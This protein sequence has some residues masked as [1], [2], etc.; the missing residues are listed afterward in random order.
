MTPREF[1]DWLI[2]YV[3]ACPN[4]SGFTDEQFRSV[5]TVLAVVDVSA[6]QTCICQYATSGP[7]H[8]TRIP[9]SRTSTGSPPTTTNTSDRDV[10]RDS[11]PGRATIFVDNKTINLPRGEHW[12]FELKM[13]AG[14]PIAH[15]LE[16]AIEG[17]L[18]ELNEGI[19]VLLNGGEQF[20]SHVRGASA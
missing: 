1:A 8:R 4:K 13:L 14:V 15:V 3:D 10:V 2:A 7:L 17:R 18:K 19:P 20:I 16:Q 12:T 6:T 5:H 11:Q 9:A